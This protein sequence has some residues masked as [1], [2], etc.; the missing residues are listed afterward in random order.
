VPPSVNVRPTKRRRVRRPA[1]PGYDLSVF[2]DSRF[3]R[4]CGGLFHTLIFSVIDFGFTLRRALPAD[5]S[6]RVRIE[7]IFAL[8]EGCRLRVHDFSRTKLFQTQGSQGTAGVAGY[9]SLRPLR[10]PETTVP[11]A[12]KINAAREAISMFVRRAAGL[13]S[14]FHCNGK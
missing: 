7:R 12:L 11:V 6:S 2:I 13:P 14:G 8:I 3:D 10:F 9:S 4:A 1:E 5:D